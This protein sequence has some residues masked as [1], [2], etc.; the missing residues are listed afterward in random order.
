MPKI[1]VATS[2]SP[3]EKDPFAFHKIASVVDA[4]TMDQNVVIEWAYVCA[5]GH[6]Y[7]CG[8]STLHIC[9]RR[10]SRHHLLSYPTK[11]G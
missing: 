7:S 2:H 4:L 6:C 3:R 9:N 11:W 1:I 8:L 10:A 5:S